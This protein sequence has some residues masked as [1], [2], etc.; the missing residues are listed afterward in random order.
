MSDKLVT[1]H[2]SAIKRSKIIVWIVHH[3]RC[4]RTTTVV[5]RRRSSDC[6]DSTDD[7]TTSTGQTIGKP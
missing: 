6:P 1:S 5:D 3:D 4:S 7:I 2:Q